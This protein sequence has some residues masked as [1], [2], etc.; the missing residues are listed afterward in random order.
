MTDRAGTAPEPYDRGAI[1][2]ALARLAGGIA[3]DFGNIL[4][5]LL[6]S[7]DNIAADTSLMKGPLRDDV[8]LA[9][10][11][12]ERGHALVQRLSALGRSQELALGPVD[13][14][15]LIRRIAHCLRACLPR[16]CDLDLNL[17]EDLWPVLVDP[18]QLEAALINLALNAGEAMS[19]GGRLE[20]RAANRGGD[21]NDGI[22]D[23]C[24]LTLRDT[25]HGMAPEIA[26]RAFERFFTTKLVGHGAGLGLAQ[27]RAF[28]E[29]VGGAVSLES[30]LGAGTTVALR[31][32]KAVLDVP[33]ILV[34]EDDPFV[35]A[36]AKTILNEH[37]YRVLSADD[38]QSALEI[39]SGH[40][41]I[42]LLFTD[43]VLPGDLTGPKLA[44]Q[45][46]RLRPGLKVLFTSG[47]SH[48]SAEEF[49]LSDEA[50]DIVVKPYRRRDLPARVKAALDQPPSFS[51]DLRAPARKSCENEGSTTDE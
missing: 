29:K 34:V 20:L 41:R 12:A 5:V 22:P 36:L 49:G 14:K 3:H 11:A 35:R 46:T 13:I 27:V 21:G 40:D 39:L 7:L 10:I 19:S 18:T 51:Q 31:L 8:K 30:T 45:A 50:L 48:A 47:Y 24:L 2:D 42:D 23:H 38:G 4:T 32:P 43:L 17:D 6:G 9:M 26:A 28:A 1:E 16:Q 25:G 37:G 15:A 33:T 44:V